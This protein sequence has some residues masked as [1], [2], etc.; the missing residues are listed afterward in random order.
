MA[1]VRDKV[2]GLAEDAYTARAITA[3]KRKSIAISF[4]KRADRERYG[5]LWSK[6]ENQFTRG[7]DHYPSD[8]VGAY[9]LLLNYKPPPRQQQRRQHNEETADDVSALTFLQNAPPTPGTDGVTHP[10]IKCYNCNVK[11]HYADVCPS[12]D[13]VTLLQVE[14]DVADIIPDTTDDAEAHDEESQDEEDDEEEDGP[15]ISEFTFVNTTSNFGFHQS[16]NI[17]PKSWILLDS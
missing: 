2:Y 10:S 5:G 1:E 13:G 15:Y 11:G 8:I 4:L 6:L 12:C 17:I 9:N 3:A 7:L 14:P 16:S